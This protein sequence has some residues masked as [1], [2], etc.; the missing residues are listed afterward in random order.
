MSVVPKERIAATQREDP[1]II[2][3][4]HSPEFSWSFIVIS[5][6]SGPIFGTERERE[7]E[8]ETETDRDRDRQ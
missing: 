2:Y 5:R 3:S 1:V 4:C 7:R 6:S 8:T